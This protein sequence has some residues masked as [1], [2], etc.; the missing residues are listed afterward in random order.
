[1]IGNWPKNVSSGSSLS[2]NSTSSPLRIPA[3]VPPKASF[4]SAISQLPQTPDADYRI[5][6]QEREPLPVGV[7]F[8]G[9]ATRFAPLSVALSRSEA[10]H[11]AIPY[12]AT[13][14]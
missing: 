9:L 3:I 2:I 5:P 13:T 10:K 12:A 8:G 11:G 1:M 6:G 7:R 14:G 4:L